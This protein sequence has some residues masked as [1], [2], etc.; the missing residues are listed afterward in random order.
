MVAFDT[1]PVLGAGVGRGSYPPMTGTVPA[2]PS[3][4]LH[5]PTAA[6]TLVVSA[7]NDHI[8]FVRLV[9]TNVAG[10]LGFDYDAIEDVRIAVSEL[11]GSLIA[12]AAPGSELTLTC[13]G[14]ADGLTVTGQAPLAEAGLHE[15]DELTEQILSAVTDTY[16]FAMDG[17]NVV[18]T[19]SRTSALTDS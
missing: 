16:S 17:T 7:A 11:C 2:M 6:V 9:A 13:R 19:M 14:D 4:D 1:P 10:K 5:T 8:S 15:P 3:A 12:V 18:F